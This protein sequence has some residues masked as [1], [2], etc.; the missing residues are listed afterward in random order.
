MSLKN[1]IKILSKILL[2]VSIATCMVSCASTAK[3]AVKVTASGAK[4][5]VQ[6][7]VKGVKKTAQATAKGARGII[8]DS[9][10]DV[11][12]KDVKD[13]RDRKDRKG[14]KR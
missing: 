12:I 9:D 8:G 14:K 10:K 7:T 11:D 13:V 6:A 4:K 1:R 2:I 3:K 5:S